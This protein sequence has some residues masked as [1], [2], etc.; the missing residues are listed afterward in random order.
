MY[1]ILIDYLHIYRIIKKR[2][3][4]LRGVFMKKFSSV[5]LMSVLFSLPVCAQEDIPMAPEIIDGKTQTSVPD[6]PN[7]GRHSTPLSSLVITPPPLPPVEIELDTKRKNPTTTQI[8]KTKPT[9]SVLQKPIPPSKPI[10]LNKDVP[11]AKSEPKPAPAPVLPKFEKKPKE[12]TPM[13][14]DLSD[15]FAETADVKRFNL[16]GFELGMT[17]DE[18]K[19]MALDTGWKIV[20]QKP[21]IPLFR[22]SFYEQQCRYQGKRIVHEINDCIERTAKNDGVFYI[23]E[24][25]LTRPKTRE[26]ISILFTSFATD[27]RAY[28]IYYQNLGDNSLGFT[29]KNMAAKLRRKEMF[30]NQMFE[31]YGYPDDADLILWGDFQKAYMQATMSGANYDAYISM[32]DKEIQDKDYFAAEDAAK[33]LRYPNQFTFFETMNDNY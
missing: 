33:E 4:K 21:A 30:W 11:I 7:L 25:I 27:N 16:S 31:A 26:S 17:P 3:S 9:E 1:H 18:V 15:L 13:P 8:E 14:T 32:E 5:L 20:A 28:K 29:P 10:E 19:D 2:S 24:I 12:P 6:Y 22:E 23:N